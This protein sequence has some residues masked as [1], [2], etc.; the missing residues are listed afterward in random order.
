MRHVALRLLTRVARLLGT[1]ADS[2]GT[3]R[4]NLHYFP[5][6]MAL[7][8]PV[9]VYRKVYLRILGGTVRIEGPVTPGMINI[10]YPRVGIFD[11]HGSRSIWES[12]G[13]VTFRGGA[14]LSHGCKVSVGQRGHLTI[15]SDAHISAEAAFVCH[16]EITI[17]DGCLL[18]WDILLMDTDFHPIYDMDGRRINEDRPIRI[19]N[20]V[21]IGCRCTILKGTVIP[22]DT[23]VAAASTVA[24]VLEGH[25]Q[26][27]GGSPARVLRTGVRWG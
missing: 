19:G 25:G 20:H 17:G 23:I 12:C 24:G 14:W 6:A 26:V 16:H 11:E 22:D 27:V 1:L 4:F 7:R 3:L 10:G 15:G 18:S 21:W 13:E 8:R 9:R 2:P 5:L